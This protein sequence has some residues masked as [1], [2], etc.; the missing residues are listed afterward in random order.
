MS[1][2]ERLLKAMAEAFASA[3]DP[4]EPI[5]MTGARAALAAIKAHN[6]GCA[7]VP[8]NP[9]EEQITAMMGGWD[10][11]DDYRRGIAASPYAKEDQG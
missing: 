10:T 7:V 3:D 4:R 9:T 1:A 2:Q 5:P 11:A 6:G 8:K